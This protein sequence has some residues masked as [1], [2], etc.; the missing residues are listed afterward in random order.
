M[1]ALNE[2]SLSDYVIS[3]EVVSYAGRA[4]CLW[5]R[6]GTHKYTD[7]ESLDSL[8]AQ[9][10]VKISIQIS[11]QEYRTTICIK[12]CIGQDNKHLKTSTPVR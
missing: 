12:I 10:D 1:T 4:P 8:E 2:V 9:G 11:L 5:T 3:S 7:F 6:A